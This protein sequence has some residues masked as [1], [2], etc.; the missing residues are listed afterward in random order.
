MT[1]LL[2]ISKLQEV[3]P[4]SLGSL[5]K[6]FGDKIYTKDEIIEIEARIMFKINL[7]FEVP[8]TL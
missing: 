6:Y 4:I 2:I 3:E 7:D 8:T 5:R 1:S